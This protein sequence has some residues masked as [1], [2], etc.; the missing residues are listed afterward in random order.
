MFAG[1]GAL[2]LEAISRGAIRATL[3]ERHIPTVRLLQENVNTLELQQLATVVTGDTFIWSKTPG[4]S[5]ACESVVFISPPYDLY[6]SHQT[7]M[8]RLI[9]LFADRCPTGSL[10]AVECD[11]RFDVSLLPEAERWDVRS[12]PP[13]RLAVLEVTDDQGKVDLP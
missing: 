13:A 6:L 12:Y 3:I 9:R 11:N 7:E 2:G 5:L 4:L 10:L 1:T 8:C